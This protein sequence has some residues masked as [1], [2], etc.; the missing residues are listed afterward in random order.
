MMRWRA[1]EAS[2][3]SA[4]VLDCYFFAVSGVV[5]PS[6]TPGSWPDG[7]DIGGGRNTT[8]PSNT[9]NPHAVP[10]ANTYLTITANVAGTNNN[11]KQTPTSN[12]QLIGKKYCRQVIIT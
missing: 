11:H 9:A 1:G 3:R 2:H 5:R 6:Q 8:L 12:T 4:F 7:A 10:I